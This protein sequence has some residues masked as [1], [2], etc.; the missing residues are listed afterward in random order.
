MVKR[1]SRGSNNRGSPK[2]RGRGGGFGRGGGRGDPPPVGFDIYDFPVQMWA[3]HDGQQPF[4]TPRGR[5]RGYRARGSNR[6][7]RGS[8]PVSRTNTPSRGNSTFPPKA[9]SPSRGNGTFQ[10]RSSTPSREFSGG[11]DHSG[12][13]LSH[14]P[15]R[16]SNLGSSAPLSSLLYE[17]RP[18]LRPILFVKSTMTPLLFQQEEELLQPTVEDIDDAEEN[19]IPTADRIAQVIGGLD[20]GDEEEIEEIDFN[21]TERLLEIQANPGK[22]SKMAWEE[23]FTGYYQSTNNSAALLGGNEKLAHANED[24][25]IEL[26]SANVVDGTTE[27][28]VDSQPENANEET[29]DITMITRD[30]KLVSTG[31]VG[32]GSSGFGSMGFFIDTTPSQIVAPSQISERTTSSHVLGEALD[33][34][35]DIIVY[36]APHPRS[37]RLTPAISTS[38]ANI[39]TKL[40]TTS[41]LTGLSTITEPPPP[42]NAQESVEAEIPEPAP[43]TS[44]FAAVKKPRQFVSP[45]LLASPSTQRKAKLRVRMHEAR[46]VRQRKWKKR[47]MFSFAAERQDK[48]WQDLDGP[49]PRWEERRRGDSDIDWGDEESKQREA[50]AEPSTGPD[51]MDVDPELLDEKSIGA[52]GLFA[53]GMLGQERSQHL[54]MDDIADIEQLKQED[55]ASEGGAEGSSDEGGEAGEQDSDEEDKDVNAVFE[56]EE[57]RMVGE[58]LEQSDEDE[59]SEE[60]EESEDELSSGSSFR[61]RLESIRRLPTKR[62][63]KNPRQLDDDDEGEA[64]FDEG[65]AWE[66]DDYINRMQE[67]VDEAEDIMT[68]RDRKE[69]KLLFKAINNGNYE[70]LST[71]TVA[72][73]KKDKPAH[74]PP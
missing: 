26:S 55:E 4:V 52:L 58:A 15:K 5:G 43:S 35:E 22:T 2:F 51:G 25:T 41:M 62:S 44:R 11:H 12:I 29:E 64:E 27:I 66:S 34:D 18:L 71:F 14:G 67:L 7:S 17:S 72:K 30:A 19:R 8:A 42:T 33:D 69:R 70:D 57:E 10:P 31:G 56:M 60:E 61:K 28:T 23:Q 65:Y 39:P 46:Y 40:S 59:E 38:N 32:V 53:D 63:P 9:S 48:E 36:V 1:K 20:L 6:G 16:K 73:R 45:L 47:S 24:Q 68:G 49:D 50:A 21:D 74:L 54:T 37:G 13:G 3:E